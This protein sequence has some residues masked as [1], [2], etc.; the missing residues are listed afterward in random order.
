MP[1]LLEG[2]VHLGLVNHPSSTSRSWFS[3]QSIVELDLLGLVFKG[4][5]VDSSE[6]M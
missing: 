4:L 1:L 3:L 5:A 2:P 6:D